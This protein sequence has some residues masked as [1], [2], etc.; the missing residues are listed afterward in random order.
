MSTMRSIIPLLLTGMMLLAACDSNT[1]QEENPDQDT[2]VHDEKPGEDYM[3]K[4][5]CDNEIKK[6]VTE[7]EERLKELEQS[8]TTGLA[9]LL[10]E[11]PLM[12][13]IEWDWSRTKAAFIDELD[14]ETLGNLIVYDLNTD[15]TV[16]M[17]D[18]SYETDELTV[19]K[20]EWFDENRILM[21]VGYRYGTVSYG[22]TLYV[23]DIE[24]GSVGEILG[25]EEGDEIIDIS[26]YGG[27]VMLECIRWNEDYTDFMT[28]VDRY[29]REEI[30]YLIER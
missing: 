15:E 17:T 28:Y 26:M 29:E 3:T 11:F 24:E 14:F 22:G 6:V 1:D 10:D 8:Q 30:E 5:D 2:V 13:D 16:K 7:Y 25:C 9:D 18:F 27:L 21:V 19:K 12:H 20:I 23:C 4:E